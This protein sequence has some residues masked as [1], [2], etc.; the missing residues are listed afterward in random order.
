MILP[1]TLLIA[2]TTTLNPTFAYAK[3]TCDQCKVIAADI[4]ALASNNTDIA[5]VVKKLETEY[6]AVQYKGKPLKKLACDAVAKGLG[7]L[8][9][10]AYKQINTLAWDSINLCAVAGLCKVKCC[11]TDTVPEQLHL[12]LTRASTSMSIG[13]TTLNATSTHMVQYGLS[14]DQLTRTSSGTTTT[15]DHFGWMGHLHNAF[16]TDL[17]PNGTKYYYRVGD[18]TGGWSKVWSFKTLYTDAGS[19]NHPLV[20]ASVGDMGYASNS[21]PTVASIA[22]LVDEGKIDFVVHNGD[23]SYADGE[24]VH[25]DI[26]MRKIE[27]IA[28][29]VPYQVTPGN[30]ELWFNFSAYKHRFVM[31]DGGSNDALYHGRV[32]G[33][34]VHFVGMDTEAWWDE[35]LINDR[36]HA[37]IDQEWKNTMATDGWKIAFGHRPLY[38]SRTKT[39]QQWYLREKIESTLN[40]YNVDLVLQAHQHDYERTWPVAQNGSVFT[41]NYD[42]PKYPVYIVNGAAGNREAEPKAPGNH[43]WQPQDQNL[44]NLISFG[45]MNVT[46]HAL[47]WDQIVS[48]DGSIQDSFTITK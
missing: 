48:S 4:A 20:V 28:A 3:V 32:V 43:P 24:Y 15:Y 31:P 10:F 12:A 45:R 21:D 7:S 23:I 26:F 22:N 40:K 29:R 9:K 19:D 5:I 8:L 17:K 11:H 1:I 16:M 34:G 18:P 13:W 6:C 47:V 41:T 44:T 46:S 27:T 42:A 25:W 14:P 37:W 38:A 36:Q 33:N 39:K 35:P 2:L 30:H